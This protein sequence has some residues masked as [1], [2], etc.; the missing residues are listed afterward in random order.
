MRNAKV[1]EPCIIVAH[2][3]GGYNARLF[4]GTYPNEVV[5]IVLLIALMKISLT[6]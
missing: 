1:K 6:V 4:A 2:S 3:I 5:G